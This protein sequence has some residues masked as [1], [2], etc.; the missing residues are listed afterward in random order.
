MKRRTGLL[1]LLSLLFS[2]ASLLFL[3]ACNDEA[4][5]ATKD[6]DEQSTMAEKESIFVPG[7]MAMEDVKI[8]FFA[9]GNE[10]DA[11]ASTVYAGAL[12]AE[13]ALGCQVEYVFSGWDSEKMTQQFREAIAQRPDGICMMGHPGVEALMP[14][15]EDA[16]DKGIYVQLLNVDVPEIREK[17]NGTLVGPNLVD[18]GKDV[19]K[20]LIEQGNLKQ[21]DMV[22]VVADW[23]Q[24]E[25]AIREKASFDYLTAQGME[26]VQLLAKPEQA[27][28]PELFIPEFTAFLAKNENVKGIVFPG[29]QHLGATPMFF[30]AANLKPGDIAIGG[31]GLDPTVLNAIKEGYVQVTA[32]QHGYMEGFMGVTSVAIHLVYGYAPISYNN[33]AAMITP[34]NYQAVE[35]VIEAGVGF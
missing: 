27:T 20:A 15:W 23:S 12:D 16:I 25:R 24:T 29:N 10:G 22:G 7:L 31:F 35:A 32:G 30:D 17:F 3:T 18:Q 26:V 5:P 28:N 9:G 11:Y 21:G 14:L 6:M 13:E 1:V 33:A 8:F 2:V 4:Q 34:D 19:A